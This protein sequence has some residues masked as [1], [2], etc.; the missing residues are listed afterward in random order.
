MSDGSSIFSDPG[1]E[2]CYLSRVQRFRRV[3]GGARFSALTNDGQEAIFDVRFVSS[4]AISAR[5]Y[6]PGEEPSLDS[7]QFAK[8]S[9]EGA[10]GKVVIRSD[11]LEL[12]VVRRPFHY[13]VFDFDGRKI[14]VQQIGD[15]DGDRVVSMPMGF[16]RAAAGQIAFHESF[17]LAPGERLLD[18]T[19]QDRALDRRGQRIETESGAMIWSSSGYA[20]TTRNAGTT[21]WELGSASPIT[22]SF[23]VEG[24]CL[25]YRLIFDET[26]V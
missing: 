13:G 22:L 23:R 7:R 20:V 5:C 16:S 6:R 4:H 24:S 10:G 15:V 19:R 12:R 1:R 25:D 18:I 11:A 21:T 2:Y 3:S 8:V 9:V 26:G 17:E 14:L